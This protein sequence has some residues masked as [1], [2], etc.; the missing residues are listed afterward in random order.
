MIQGVVTEDREVVICL[1]IRGADGRDHEVDAVIDTGFDGWLSLPAAA[2]AEMGFEWRQRGRAFL[3]DGGE[4]VFDIY[5]DI[6]VWDGQP[7]RVP[8]HQAETT[9]LVGMSLLD[10]YEVTFQVRRSGNVIIRKLTS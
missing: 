6:V 3:A 8:I 1:T 5:E 4:S 7:R 10:D 2:L 9:P